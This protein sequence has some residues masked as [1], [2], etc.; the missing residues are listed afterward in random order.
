MIPE[1]PVFTRT[2]LEPVRFDLHNRKSLVKDMIINVA[3]FIPFGFFFPLWLGKVATWPRGRIVIASIAA[4][5]FLSLAI[6]LTQGFIPVRSSSQLD[7]VCNTLG[8]GV[9]L[10]IFSRMNRL[11]K[12][13]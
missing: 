9:G 11:R 4:A 5:F 12:M 2:V 3:G 13:G 7:V 10:V 1:A 6:E 8:M